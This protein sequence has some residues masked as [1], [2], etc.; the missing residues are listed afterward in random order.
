MQGDRIL[1]EKENLAPGL[2]GTFSPALEPGDYT[3]VCPGAG[4]ESARSRSPR[5]R[6]VP[7]RAARRPTLL[8][9]ATPGTRPT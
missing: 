6:A 7:P 2:A 5:P 9:A 3:V 4:T 8:A 1:G